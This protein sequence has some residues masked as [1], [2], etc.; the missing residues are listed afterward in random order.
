MESQDNREGGLMPARAVIEYFRVT[1]RT[2]DRWLRSEK[3]NF[4]SPA[5]INNRRYW[6]RSEIEAWARERRAAVAA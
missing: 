1:D 5:V 4:P 3:L 6:A 2:I